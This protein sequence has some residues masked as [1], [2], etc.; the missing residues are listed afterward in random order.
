MAKIDTDTKILEDGLRYKS[1]VAGSPFKC[2]SY[3]GT[4]TTMSCLLCGKHRERSFLVARKIAGK[5]QLCCAPSC[6][7][8]DE[9]VASGATKIVTKA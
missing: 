8:V 5:N 6:K 1:K 2:S 3:M 9:A 4:N 7:A